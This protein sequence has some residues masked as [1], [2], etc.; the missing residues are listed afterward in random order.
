MCKT[1]KKESSP[2]IHKKEISASKY[3]I[4]E[5][6]RTLFCLL[7]LSKARQIPKNK[8]I[9]SEI[10]TEIIMNIPVVGAPSVANSIKVKINIKIK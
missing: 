4:K 3:N 7:N 1:P 2:D 10:P 9:N 6:I 8:I 5:S